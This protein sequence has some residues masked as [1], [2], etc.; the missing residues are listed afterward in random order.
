MAIK[1]IQIRVQDLTVGMYVSGLDRPWSQTPFPLQ[2]FQIRKPEDIE[3]IRS[4]CTQVF[5]DVTKG[6]GPIQPADVIAVVPSSSTDD[7]GQAGFSVQAAPALAERGRLQARQERVRPSPITIRRGVY[8]NTRPMRLEAAEAEKI[9]R[10]LKGQ[11]ILATKQLAKGKALEYRELQRVGDRMVDSVLRCPDAFTWLLRLRD[12]DQYSHEHTLRSALWAVQFA[13]YAGMERDQISI[14]C[15]GALLK[16]IG[17][18]RL[19][20]SLLRKTLRT[21]EEEVQ[22]RKFVDYGV[23][24]LREMDSVGPKVISVV[25]YHCEKMDGSGFPL[26][27][28]GNKIPLLAR[29]LG[30]A[31]AYDLIS[32]PRDAVE[33][34]SPSKAVSTLYNMRDS[35]FQEDLVVHF[36]QSVGLYPPGT[37][38]ELST[39][40]LGV[41]L[42]QDPKSRLAP[43]I[44]VLDTGGNDLSEN[45]IFVDLRDQDGARQALI[46]SGRTGAASV[47]K[48]AIARDLEPT[49]YDIDFERVSASYLHQVMDAPG[50]PGFFSGLKQRLFG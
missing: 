30:V 46:E 47:P 15:M 6:R 14:L 9:V 41:V 20:T 50:R 29:I 7:A 43:K 42:E 31:T 25:R 32:S 4:Y 28:A 48:L 45:C 26:G 19:P 5:I 21:P 39:G 36:I 8:E 13:R 35:D 16:D 2:G 18:T 40:D 1:E 37:L 38:V 10:E 11:L 44:A 12:K 24:I 3:T 27:I 33:P 23:E 34:I 22:Y 49:S 17:K